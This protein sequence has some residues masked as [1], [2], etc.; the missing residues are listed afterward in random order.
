MESG[1]T[2]EIGLNRVLRF[3]GSSALPAYPGLRVMNIAQ[4]LFKVILASSSY[5]FGC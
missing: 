3:I 2:I 4:S 1:T 5:K